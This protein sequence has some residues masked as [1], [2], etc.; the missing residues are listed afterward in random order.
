MTL[1]V[2]H[3][4]RVKPGA[5]GKFTPAC[6]C[7]LPESS[8]QQLALLLDRYN[9]DATDTMSPP[10]KDK[11]LAAIKQLQLG[12]MYAHQPTKGPLPSEL[13]LTSVWSPW[14]GRKDVMAL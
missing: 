11:L 14:A 5:A 7:A 10:Q 2:S 9:L 4:F 6:L 8:L 1:H 3:M 13:D 12:D